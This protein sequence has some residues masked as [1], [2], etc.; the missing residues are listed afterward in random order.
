M[1]TMWLVMYVLVGGTDSFA[2]PI[3]GT[4]VLFLI[5]EAFRDL[6]IYAPFVS[7]VILLLVVYLAPK[8]LVG[9]PGLIFSSNRRGVVSAPSD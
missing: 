9:L 5:P 8:G 3:V 4:L 7:G 6:K 2:G 1:A